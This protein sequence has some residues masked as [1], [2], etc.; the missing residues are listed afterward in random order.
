MLVESSISEVDMFT[1]KQERVLL[2]W[3]GNLPCPCR[4]G[5]TVAVHASLYE[6]HSVDVDMFLRL[7]ADKGEEPPAS[8]KEDVLRTY[9]VGAELGLDLHRRLRVQSGD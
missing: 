9:I 7:D 1:P 2:E 8:H 6:G 4:C 3:K 5:A